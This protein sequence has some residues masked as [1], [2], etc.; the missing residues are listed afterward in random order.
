[1]AYE[2][3]KR[4]KGHDYLYLVDS[5][6]DPQTNR[7]KARWHYVG[8]VDN[9]ALR[10]AQ[11]RQPR[12][13][14]TREDIIAATARLL[15]FR[16]PEHITVG[17]ISTSAGASRSAFYRHFRNQQEAM[18]EALVRIANELIQSLPALDPPNDLG[19]ARS[20]LRLWCETYARSIA[21]HRAM[22]R[23]LMLGYAGEVRA[24]LECSQVNESP[25]ARLSMFF[26]QLNDAGFAAIEDPVA[27]ARAVRGMHLALRVSTILASPELGLSLPKYEEVYRLI[28]R[29][30]FG[31][32]SFEPPMQ[33]AG[34]GTN[35]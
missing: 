6:R 3:T 28:E 2:V 29:A 32:L 25:V 1:M 20:Q 31:T 33:F 11:P 15:E 12:R 9:G 22:E 7:R 34:S 5:Y 26:R 4:I 24:R 23:A 30:V 17:V 21:R 35:G 16:D 27:L 18:T 13:R 10:A 14:I 19:E 8:V